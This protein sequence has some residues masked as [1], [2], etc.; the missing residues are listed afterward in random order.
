M[1]V[2]G[3]RRHSA[4]HSGTLTGSRSTRRLLSDA[5]ALSTSMDYDRPENVTDKSTPNQQAVNRR[6]TPLNKT[7]VADTQQQQTLRSEA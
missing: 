5:A 6:R 7:A 2:I 3:T 4:G 1:N